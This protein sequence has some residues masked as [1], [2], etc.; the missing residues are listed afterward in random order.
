[1]FEGTGIAVI[2][3]MIC[4][5]AVVVVVVWALMSYNR[6]VRLRNQ[7]TPRGRRSTCSSSGG[8]T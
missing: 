2:G 8:T 5:L 3:G 1:M 4:L 6:L 7:A